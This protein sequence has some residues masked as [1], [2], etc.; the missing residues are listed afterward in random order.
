GAAVDR[1]RTSLCGQNRGRLSL[2]ELR[3]GGDD[4]DLVHLYVGIRG[5][6]FPGGEKTRVC[7][8]ALARS[9]RDPLAAGRVPAGIAVG[10]PVAIA[11]SQQDGSYVPHARRADADLASAPRARHRPPAAAG[12]SGETAE[13]AGGADSGQGTGTR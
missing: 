13:K 6:V 11:A 12:R 7:P 8:Y 9:R 4:A 5:D 10:P 3:G 1:H 2:G